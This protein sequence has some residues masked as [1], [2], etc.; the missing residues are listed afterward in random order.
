MVSFTQGIAPL[1]DSTLKSLAGKQ[2]IVESLHFK[3]LVNNI[4]KS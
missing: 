4:F 3:S 2:D 1:G